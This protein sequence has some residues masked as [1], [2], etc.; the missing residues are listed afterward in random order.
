MRRSSSQ[1][2]PPQLELK[3]ALK[4]KSFKLGDRVTVEVV[5]T[6]VEKEEL[7]LVLPCG[8]PYFN[9]VLSDWTGHPIDLAGKQQP[10]ESKRACKQETKYLES[11]D[12]LVEEITLYLYPGADYTTPEKDRDK[13]PDDKHKTFLLQASTRSLTVDQLGQLKAADAQVVTKK[14]EKPAFMLREVRRSGFVEIEI[15]R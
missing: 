4:S 9:V 2:P 14:L 12:R 1:E 7:L 10:V 8:R 3:I 6:N 15:D 13:V 11:G 5:A